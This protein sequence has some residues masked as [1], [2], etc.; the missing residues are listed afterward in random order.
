MADGIRQI[1]LLTAVNFR[2]WRK[3]PQIWLAFG[4]GFVACFLLTNK[5]VLFA[6]AHDTVMQVFEPFIW[7][8]GDAKSILLI[9]LCLLLLFADMPSLGA[10]VPLMLIRTTRR[11]WMASQ[12]L[13]LAL[14]TLIFI[15]FLLL[16]SC[17]LCAQYGYPANIWSE[18]AAILSYSS[19]G[20]KIAVPAF[21]KVLELTY[22]FPCTVHIFLLMLG[23]SMTLSGLMFLGNLLKARLGMILGIAFSGFGFFL[24][25]DIVS[26]W[27]HLSI[28]QSRKA[29][30]LFGWLSPLNHA[31]YYMHNF[32]YDNLPRLQTSYLIFAGTAAILFLLAFWRS[33]KYAFHFTGTER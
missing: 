16:S 33:K 32:G 31:T 8:F 27:F 19:I 3:S 28:Y 11:R 30:I 18:T 2:R 6:Q 1:L 9:S 26:Q 4:L 20:Q 25:P 17:L 10:E 12:I 15:A 5:T 7:T 24:N 13:Y 29:N 22:P 23:Y 21:V 14:A